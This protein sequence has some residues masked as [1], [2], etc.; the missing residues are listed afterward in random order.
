MTNEPIPNPDTQ[1]VVPLEERKSPLPRILNSR[2]ALKKRHREIIEGKDTVIDTLSQRVGMDA[3]TEIPNLDG[4]YTR[5]TK[6][7]DRMQRSNETLT[8][9][10]L[11]VNFL[12]QMNDHV[13]HMHGDLTLEKVASIIK[14]HVRTDD[15]IARIGGDEFAILLPNADETQLNIVWGR[16][17]DALDVA[18]ISVGAG[19]INIKPEELI[20]PIRMRT[21]SELEKVNYIKDLTKKLKDRADEPMYRAKFEAKNPQSPNFKKCVLYS[22]L[23]A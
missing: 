6:T 17:K 3:L 19:A 11:D 2:R 20:D 10:M 8:F 12:K 18:K 21:M 23:P 5:L 1:S 13:G 16:I 4:F 22:E 9:V 7:I 15:S 14:N